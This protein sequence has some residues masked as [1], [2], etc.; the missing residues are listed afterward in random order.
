MDVFA[1]MGC[2]CGVENI[3]FSQPSNQVVHV[4][5]DDFGEFFRLVLT[6]SSFSFGLKR[7]CISKKDKRFL[8]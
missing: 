8:Y 7:Y 3:F 6:K 2:E 1:N 4:F 5:Y